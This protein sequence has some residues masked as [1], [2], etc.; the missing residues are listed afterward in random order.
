MTTRYF[1][2]VL[3]LAFLIILSSIITAQDSA[4]VATQVV[5]FEQPSVLSIKPEFVPPSQVLEILGVRQLGGCN[6]I[7]WKTKGIY[8]IVEIRHNGPANLLILSGSKNDVDYVTELIREV[9]IAPRQIEIEIKIVE[10]N[11][12]KAHEIGL[13]WEQIWNDLAP[14]V[15]LRYRENHDETSRQV[16]NA[17]GM[18][19]STYDGRRLISRSYD[20]SSVA[21]LGASL[22]ILDESGVA[23]IRNAPRILTLNNRRATILDGDRVT[24]V[25]RY[26]SYTNLYETDS[27]DAGLTMSVLPSIGESGYITL[28]LNAEFT[29]I[30][31]NISG[32]PIKSGQLIENTIIVKDGDSVLLGGLSRTIK[33]KHTKRFPILG[34]ILPFLFSHESMV[35]ESI[36]S[37]II[38]TTRVVDFDTALKIDPVS[39]VEG[40]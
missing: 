1:R 3:F 21:D 26:S 31:G 24:Y 27:M 12:S 13:D 28:E 9:D 22:D 20:V 40:N 14:R 16:F 4:S 18:E 15:N 37:F 11:T 2:S 39:P 8:H 38:L 25:T 33:T 35:D 34:H 6:V 36:E 30:S 17:A 32:S 19:S 7:D 23:E 10:I 29:S 5:P